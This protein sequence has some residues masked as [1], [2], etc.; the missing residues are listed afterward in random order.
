MPGAQK[1]HQNEIGCEKRESDIAT[2]LYDNNIYVCRANRRLG[3]F[4]SNRLT[5]S[6]YRE[7][8]V[9]AIRAIYFCRVDEVD[10]QRPRTVYSV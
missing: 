10:K 7:S 4:H 8:D 1:S 9:C 6:G 2:G 5:G 3:A